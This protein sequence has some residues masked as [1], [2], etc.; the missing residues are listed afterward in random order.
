MLLQIWLQLK[1]NINQKKF[2]F[3][4]DVFAFNQK[5]LNEFKV[6]YREKI[7]LPFHC[8]VTPSTAKDEILEGLKEAGCESVSMGI[9]SGNE[10][11]RTKMLHRRHTDELIIAAAQRIKKTWFKTTG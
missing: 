2:R 11:I 4:D 7:N 5:W 3:E 6:A 8:Y 1:K 10:K 9:Q